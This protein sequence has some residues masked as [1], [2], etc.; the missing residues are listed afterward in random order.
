MTQMLTDFPEFDHDQM[1]ERVRMQLAQRITR[2]M[3]KFEIFLDD[4]PRDFSPGQI[5]NYLAA[6]KLLGSLYQAHQRP[7][8]K[9]GMIPADKVEKLMAAACAQAVEDALTQERARIQAERLMALESAG[10]GIRDALKRERDR[11]SRALGQ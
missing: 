2:L 11:Q 7:V 6:A 8:D 3:D 9:S 10:S 5:A 1:S 4:D